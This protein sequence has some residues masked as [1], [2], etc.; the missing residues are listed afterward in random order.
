MD[1][2]RIAK[3]FEFLAAECRPGLVTFLTA[4]DPNTKMSLQTLLQ[5]PAAGADIIELGMPF[6]DPMADGPVIQASSQ[7]ALVAGANMKKNPRD[8]YSL[9]GKR[10]RNTLGSHGLLQPRLRLWSR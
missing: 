7:R 5:L 8:G 10:S 4:G 6:S 9:Q 2:S 1:T 3:K